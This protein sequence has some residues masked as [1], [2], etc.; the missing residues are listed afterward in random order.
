MLYNTVTMLLRCCFAVTIPLTIRSV[1]QTASSIEGGG[2]LKARPRVSSHTTPRTLGVVSLATIGRA[3]TE[4]PPS[5]LLLHKYVIDTAVNVRLFDLPC[6][7]G[8]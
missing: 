8:P 2:S 6:R 1:L 4:P 3:V 7:P 5:T